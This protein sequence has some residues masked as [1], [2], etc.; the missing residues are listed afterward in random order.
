LEVNVADEVVTPT[1]EKSCRIPQEPIQMLKWGGILEQAVPHLL[2]HIK[3]PGVFCP[4]G[5][6]HEPPLS[7]GLHIQPQ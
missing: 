7:G 1:L 4:E 3:E 5:L 6:E 2:Y